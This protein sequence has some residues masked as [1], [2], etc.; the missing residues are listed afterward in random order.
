MG[1]DKKQ[2]EEK[3]A[4]EIE[5]LTKQ[6]E[7]G[8]LSVFQSEEYIKLLDV[9]A[10]MPNYSFGNHILIAMQRPDAS[11][12]NSYTGWKRVNRFVNA[13]E[14]GIR[15]LAP[16]PY[17]K[18]VLQEARDENGNII[19]DENGEIVKEKVKIK[20]MAFKPVS[21]FDIAQT[22]GQPLPQIGV[23]ELEGQVNK[24]DVLLSTL[25][26]VS[27]VPIS[28]EDIN[29]GAKGYYHTLEKRIVIQAGMDEIQTIKTLIH[30][31]AHAK[32]HS[33]EQEDA[34][35]KKSRAQKECEAESIAYVC[36]RHLDIDTSDYSF[37]YIAVW[38]G[39]KDSDELKA[40]L[41][42]IRDSASEL[43]ELIDENINCIL[44]NKEKNNELERG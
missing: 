36:C 35:N 6:L 17:E 29:S 7:E 8:I 11:L 4:A 5:E 18:V 28:F 44:Q 39:D 30:E 32:Y 15:I 14:K 20:V 40:S 37:G 43:I 31:I 19:R 26:K 42:I 41:K 24:Y 25:K 16:A 23:K 2:A 10:K 9:M 34:L 27:P 33:K 12:C 13:G 1:Y 22:S 21:T 38:A 3:R